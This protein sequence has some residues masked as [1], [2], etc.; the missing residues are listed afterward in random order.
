MSNAVTD[1]AV[2]A[3]TDSTYM[4]P[5]WEAVERL[6]GSWAFKYTTGAETRLYDADDLIQ[7]G[8][9][10][11]VD[12]LQSF[13]QTKGEFVTILHFHVRS[14]FNEVA[15][16]RGTKRDA[17]INATSLD[18]PLMD[19]SDTTRAEMIPDPAAE[20]EESTV[21][22]VYTGE[23]RAALDECLERLTPE[24]ADTLRARHYDNRSYSDIA[25][26]RNTS[27][28]IVRREE[29]NGLRNMRRGKNYTRLK[30]WREDIISRSYQFGGYKMFMYSG[31]SSVEYTVEKLIEAE[32]QTR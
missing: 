12:A 13:D 16:I 22:R 11:M 26:E 9:I 7:A 5:L 19:E 21:E 3:R 20:F 2:N 17:V 24:Q 1:L 23:L 10:A 27:P 4:L 15:G 28:D 32:E 14:R 25:T 30:A 18:V 31:Y 8:Y 6:I 29:S